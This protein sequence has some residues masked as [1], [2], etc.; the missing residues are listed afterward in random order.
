MFSICLEL[1]PKIKTTAMKIY[2]D[3]SS[4]K[5]L[6]RKKKT[7]EHWQR[8]PAVPSGLPSLHTPE[9]LDEHE[10]QTLERSWWWC[11]CCTACPPAPWRGDGPRP[12]S[13]LAF[14]PCARLSTEQRRFLQIKEQKKGIIFL[15]SKG[16]SLAFPTNLG[17]Y[18]VSLKSP[19][20]FGPLTLTWNILDSEVNERHFSI[21]IWEWEFLISSL[22]HRV[23]TRS[24]DT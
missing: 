1:F 7:W 2:R 12:A 23:E 19:S 18:S 4:N 15:H 3:I 13:T 20:A 6:K 21:L 10:L 11:S 17:L 24:F 9:D 16:Q 14:E 22:A 5:I 8:P